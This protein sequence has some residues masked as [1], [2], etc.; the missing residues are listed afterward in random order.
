MMI[1]RCCNPKDPS[2]HLY[3]GAG[4][5]VCERWKGCPKVFEEWSLRNGWAEGTRIG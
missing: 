2:F 1:N 5:M 3:G 4:V